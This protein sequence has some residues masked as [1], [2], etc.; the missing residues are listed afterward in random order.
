[1]KQRQIKRKSM[2]Q[3]KAGP[4]KTTFMELIQELSKL[5]QDDSLVMAAIRNIFVTYNVVAT[6]TLAPVKL[7][8]SIRPAQRRVNRRRTCW[9]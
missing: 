1:M 8:P 6:R 2:N 3:T 5:T 7:V 4:I 9:A